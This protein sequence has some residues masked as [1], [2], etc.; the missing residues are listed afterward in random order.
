MGWGKG[1]LGSKFLVGVKA[2][3]LTLT[4]RCWKVESPSKGDS[5][6]SSRR[7]KHPGNSRDKSTPPH[8]E[9]RAKPSIHGADLVPTL[10]DTL[11]IC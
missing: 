7:R 2:E 11:S 5:M 9:P 1:G 4:L 3:M 6:T 8:F 10:S